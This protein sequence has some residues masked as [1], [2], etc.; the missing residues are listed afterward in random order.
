MKNILKKDDGGKYKDSNGQVFVRENNNF[1]SEKDGK[2]IEDRGSIMIED[3]NGKMTDIN[4]KRIF[5]EKL[6]G[7][8]FVDGKEVRDILSISKWRDKPWLNDLYIDVSIDDV[9]LHIE[10][11]DLKHIKFGFHE[12]DTGKL[13]ENGKK[14]VE[15]ILYNDGLIE[16]DG[17]KYVIGNYKFHSMSRSIGKVKNRGGNI[18]DNIFL[19]S[20]LMAYPGGSG[21]VVIN[22]EGRL[23]GIHTR[24][25]YGMEKDEVHTKHDPVITSYSVPTKE[26]INV[27]NRAQKYKNVRISYTV[28]SGS[29][30]NRSEMN[31][32]DSDLIGK[33]S[34]MK[35][36]D[37]EQN[38]KDNS[39]VVDLKNRKSYVD[40]VRF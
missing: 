7:K 34:N 30:G 27:I 19:E 25:T 36:I 15:K 4:H 40:T 13:D 5:Y 22:S 17:K 24:G 37:Q 32:L 28:D 1:Y 14:I 9:F 35:S 21:C 31:F 20:E 2:Q 8:L 16:R 23:L 11:K 39:K 33:F 3:K 38:N 6:N 26:I 12:K 29:F 18:N 10:K